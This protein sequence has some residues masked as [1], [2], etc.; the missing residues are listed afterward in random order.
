VVE[1]GQGSDRVEPEQL[2][3]VPAIRER[4][5]KVSAAA[6]LSLWPLSGVRGA[7]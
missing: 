7:G 1:T 4:Q 6:E 2:L 5:G 3:E